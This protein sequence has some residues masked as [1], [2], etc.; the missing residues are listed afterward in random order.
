M[1][2]RGAIG[3]RE[4]WRRRRRGP[5]CRAGRP[6]PCLDRRPNPGRA[7]GRGVG[8]RGDGREA[9][10]SGR[11]RAL[12]DEGARRARAGSS[13]RARRRRRR[14]RRRAAAR[15]ARARRRH[16]R[17]LGA[18]RCASAGRHSPAANWAFER[19]PHAR[20]EQLTRGTTTTSAGVREADEHTS[21]APS[22][23]KT[24]SRWRSP[25]AWTCPSSPPRRRRR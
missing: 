19:V 13:A 20:R 6:R 7:R 2:H 11:G 8:A 22:V 16:D 18:A 12:D 17:R 21:R 9:P 4:G 24:W 15:D 14:R 5:S 10:T 25:R 3:R 23:P 1:T